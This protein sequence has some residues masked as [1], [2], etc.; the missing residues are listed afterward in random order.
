MEDIEA[1][2]FAKN[3]CELRSSTV[4]KTV[5]RE[6]LWQSKGRLFIDCE[7]VHSDIVKSSCELQ[8]T[9]LII[10]EPNAPF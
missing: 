4:K 2:T 10:G 7:V 6:A 5:E 1:A 8:L 3:S 9:S